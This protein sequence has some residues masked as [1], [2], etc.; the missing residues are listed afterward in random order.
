M[1]FKKLKEEQ[2]T[3]NKFPKDKIQNNQENT[4]FFVFNES[5]RKWIRFIN[6]T[7]I[8]KK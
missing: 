3:Q 8:E 5:S 2:L 6:K 4:M 1:N 7:H